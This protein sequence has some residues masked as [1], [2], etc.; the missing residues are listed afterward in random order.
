VE[1]NTDL[2]NGNGLNQPLLLDA[3]DNEDIEECD[4]SEEAS[5]DSRRPASS[6]GEAYRLLTP[7]I[8]VQSNILFFPFFVILEQ[9][10]VLLICTKD[11][12][13]TF[14]NMSFIC[15]SKKYWNYLTYT[16]ILYF[17][18]FKIDWI[19]FFPT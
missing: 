17:F 10:P 6:I 19:V 11:A 7:S 18:F 9:F 3:K 2:E 4:D 13:I 14:I 15:P 12:C 1:H 5:T 16:S 8:K